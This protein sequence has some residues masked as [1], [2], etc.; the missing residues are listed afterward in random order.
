[1]RGPSREER[2]HRLIR[3]QADL[4]TLATKAAGITRPGLC[5][6]ALLVDLILTLS[7][8]PDN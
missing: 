2:A 8:P 7:W 4:K 3:K 6:P 5:S 1:M